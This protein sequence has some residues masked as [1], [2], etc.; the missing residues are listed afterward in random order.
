[1]VSEKY[2]LNLISE[3]FYDDLFEKMKSH[4]DKASDSHD[5]IQNFKQ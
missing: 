3:Q 4:E 2:E 1:M 5:V